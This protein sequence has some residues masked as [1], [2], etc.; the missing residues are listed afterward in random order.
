MIEA[1]ATILKAGLS[2]TNRDLM[3][4][5]LRRKIAILTRRAATLRSSDGG[6]TV[7]LFRLIGIFGK[8]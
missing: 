7:R 3:K 5:L 1:S 6:R 2:E 4:K 8:V